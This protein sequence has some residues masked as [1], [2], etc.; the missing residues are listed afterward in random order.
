MA[1]PKRVTKGEAIVGKLITTE[2]IIFGDGTSSIT[3][4]NSYYGQVGSQTQSTITVGTAGTYQSTG[5]TA[6][7]DTSANSGIS[8][9]T[10]NT[11]AIKNTSGETRIFQ[12]YAS[13]DG[14]VTGAAKT[15]GLRLALNG[16]SI[17]STE[18]RATT[19]A[20]G[21]IAKLITVS[22]I[23]LENNDEV[24]LFLTNHTDTASISFQRGRI[25]A[26]TV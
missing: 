4:Q 17:A 10:T 3:G 26:T 11:F 8:L 16:I 19:S 24:A 9:G 7:L 12:I 13:Y 14:T 23:Q 18:C 25:V 6:T 5:L 20:A 22:L 1:N 21:A 15:L 2:G